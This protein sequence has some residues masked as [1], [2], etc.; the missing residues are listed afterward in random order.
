MSHRGDGC[1]SLLSPRPGVSGWVSS[2]SSGWNEGRQRAGR[3]TLPLSRPAGA[4]PL[5][6]F[7]AN[8]ISGS[9]DGSSPCRGDGEK[10]GESRCSESH[11]AFGSSLLPPD[12]HPSFRAASHRDAGPPFPNPPS[13]PS[14]CTPALLPHPEKLPEAEQLRVTRSGDTTALGIAFAKDLG[15]CHCRVPCR[16]CSLSAGRALGAWFICRN[17]IN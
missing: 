16:P 10:G 2:A 13:A 17:T 15:K 1:F 3:A 5:P 7:M 9:S 11:A 14:S 4:S 12:S 6:F 8:L